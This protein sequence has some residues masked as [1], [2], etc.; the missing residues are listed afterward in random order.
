M[1]EQELK[2]G[3]RSAELHTLNTSQESAGS[4]LKSM[5]I[6]DWLQCALDQI[7]KGS[8][9]WNTLVDFTLGMSLMTL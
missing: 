4:A 5:G 2:F 9:Q 3:R 7:Q 8:I 1:S 6:F